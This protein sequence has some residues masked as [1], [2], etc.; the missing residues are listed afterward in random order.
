MHGVVGRAVTRSGSNRIRGSTSLSHTSENEPGLVLQLRQVFLLS[1]GTILAE[2]SLA[3]AYAVADYCVSPSLSCLC[4]P[5]STEGRPW[6]QHLKK[7]E[8]TPLNLR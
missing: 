3:A 5:E 2:I 8:D 7:P 1:S 4:K 6:G